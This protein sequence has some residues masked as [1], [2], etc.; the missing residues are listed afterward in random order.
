MIGILVSHHFSTKFLLCVSLNS[1]VWSDE[2]PQRDTSCYVGLLLGQNTTN[3]PTHDYQD[4][5]TQSIWLRVVL[6]MYDSWPVWRG[7]IVHTVHIW[8][9]N[10]MLEL[11]YP[12]KQTYLM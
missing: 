9:V 3:K 5:D 2:H 7:G 10:I 8:H 11:T 12:L 4:K 6:R 1:V